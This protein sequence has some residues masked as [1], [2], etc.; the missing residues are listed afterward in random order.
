MT[1]LLVLLILWTDP[2]LGKVEQRYEVRTAGHYNT[3]KR[4]EERRKDFASG[5]NAL[6]LYS[7]CR[8]A[9]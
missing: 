3:L 6:V 9:D 2:K 1:Y 7:E 5:S 4:C 8:A